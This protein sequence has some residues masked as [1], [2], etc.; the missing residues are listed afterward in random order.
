MAGAFFPQPELEVPEKEMSEHAGDHMVDP[1]GEFTHLIVVHPEFRFR[2][3]KALLDSPA[4][5][6]QPY[7][8]CEAGAQARIADE[9]G[10]RRGII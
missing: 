5:A 3:L 8:E 9:I 6:T 4:N 10:I 2:F 1:A 7:E